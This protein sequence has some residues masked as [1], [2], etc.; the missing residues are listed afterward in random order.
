MGGQSTKDFLS[1]PR[2]GL[3]ILIGVLCEGRGK[4]HNSLS[5]CLDLQQTEP[6]APYSEK[7]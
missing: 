5:P 2:S 7:P 3:S 6:E 1:G 4:M